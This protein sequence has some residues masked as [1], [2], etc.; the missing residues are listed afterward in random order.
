MNRIFRILT[1]AALAWIPLASMAGNQSDGHGPFGNYWDQPVRH[2]AEL[3][4]EERAR[5]R[6]QWQYLPPAEREAMLK[7][8]RQQWRETPPEERHRKQEEWMKRGRDRDDADRSRGRKQSGW[9][10]GYGQGYE[11]RQWE[12]PEDMQRPFERPEA[13]SGGRGRR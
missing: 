7:E 3:T 12:R 10:D 6:D 2:L 1:L 8:L 5:F 11:Y 4:R 9:E 13:A